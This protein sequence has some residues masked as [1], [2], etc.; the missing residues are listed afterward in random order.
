MRIRLK[1]VSRQRSSKPGQCVQATFVTCSMES[2]VA[3]LACMTK[4]EMGYDVAVRRVASK[5]VKVAGG[6]QVWA[7]TDA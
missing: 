3:V 6:L 4:Y 2:M 1:R 7:G 5:N